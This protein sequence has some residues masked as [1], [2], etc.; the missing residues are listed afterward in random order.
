MSQARQRAAFAHLLRRFRASA[1]EPTPQRWR[2]L[3]AAHVLG[4]NR[5]DLHWRSHWHML[6]FALRLGDGREARGQLARLA[7]TPLGHLVRRLPQGNIG[8]A[9]VPALQ[10]MV[11]SP[12]VRACITAAM[13]ATQPP[14]ASDTN[15]N[16]L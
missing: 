4:Q 10:P 6:R 12:A 8:R 9:N 3:E 1:D 5:L 2:Y 14:G 13:A 7:L 16:S 15:Q 11:P